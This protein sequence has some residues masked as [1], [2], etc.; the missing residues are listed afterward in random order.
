[1]GVDAIHS[2]RKRSNQF[3]SQID[4]VVA[5]VV[6]YNEDL[7]QLNRDQMNVSMLAD[8]GTI[9]S[10]YAASYAYYKQTYY[11]TSYGQ[12]NVNFKLTGDLHAS[13]EIKAK[14]RDYEITTDVPY[15]A[16]LVNKYGNFLGIAPP[17]QPKAQKI[18]TDLLRQQWINDV[19]K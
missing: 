17:Y 11:P 3:V 16:E 13:I 8:G 12:G 14:G 18:T 4:R 19:L 9:T 7:E 15:A 2:L 10:G 5:D 6:D 1:M